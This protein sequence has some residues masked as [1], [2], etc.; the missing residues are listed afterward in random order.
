[1]LLQNSSGKLFMCRVRF[2]KLIKSYKAVL[3][4]KGTPSFPLCGLSG[5]I[6]FLLKKNQLDFKAENLLQDPGLHVFLRE[7]NSPSSVPYLYV[8]EKFIGGYDELMAMLNEENFQ[9]II[10]GNFCF[11]IPSIVESPHW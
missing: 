7:K 1:M 2:E 9:D 3:F 6:C 11:G 4:M 5:T 8:N 10:Q